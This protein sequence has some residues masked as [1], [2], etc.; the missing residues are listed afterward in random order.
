MK[1]TPPQLDAPAV[2]FGVTQPDVLPITGA[3]VQH[4]GL[5]PAKD[6]GPNT[7]LYAFE[8]DDKEKEMI[9]DGADLYIALVTFGGPPQPILPIIG[10]KHAAEIFDKR[11]T[12]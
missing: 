8:F 6:G 4:D 1:S 10:V 5:P 12:P 2:V 9:I 7:V 3:L 11:V